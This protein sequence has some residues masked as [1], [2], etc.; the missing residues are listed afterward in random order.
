MG[1]KNFDKVTKDD[2]I[3]RIKEKD[4]RLKVAVIRRIIALEHE[5]I[6]DA[7]KEG[8]EVQVKDHMTIYPYAQKS[9]N[10]YNPYKQEGMTL[11]DRVI[12][13]VELGEELKNAT[14]QLDYDKIKNY[15]K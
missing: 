4:D 12:T 8:K 11:P 14:K 13:K 7:L 9:R 15:K 5:A 3:N 6:T 10:C 2:L 1:K